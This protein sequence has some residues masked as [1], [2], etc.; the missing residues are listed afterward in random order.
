MPLLTDEV[1]PPSESEEEQRHPPKAKKRV[2]PPSDDES[3]A[4][5]AVS[6]PPPAKKQH[7]RSL[8]EADLSDAPVAGKKRISHY[9]ARGERGPETKHRTEVKT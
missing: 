7:S 6:P 9:A 3:S 4:S 8:R 5:R 1:F 2:S